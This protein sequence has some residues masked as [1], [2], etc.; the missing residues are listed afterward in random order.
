MIKIWATLMALLFAPQ[1]QV[2]NVAQVQK[3]LAPAVLLH[4]KALRINDETREAQKILAGCSGTFITEGTV[5][6]AA[7]CFEDTILNIWVKDTQNRVFEGKLVKIDVPHDLALVS[8]IHKKPHAY[9]TL[10]KSVRRGEQV[11][12]VGSPFSLGI[13]LSEGIVSITGLTL[14]PFTGT[15]FLQTGMINPGSSG[16]GALNEN[17]EL[18]GVNTLSIGGFFGWAGVSGTVDLKTVKEFLGRK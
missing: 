11:V 16:G 8:V 7:H 2:L 1:T 17:G 18:M 15:Y 6:T 3:A 5:L 10:A 14:K 9:V 4:I 13:M 12:N